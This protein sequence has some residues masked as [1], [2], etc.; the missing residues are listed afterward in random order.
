MSWKMRDP[1]FRGDSKL[2]VTPPVPST[3]LSVVA[4]ILYLG[5]HGRPT[6]YTSV[7]ELEA[8][9]E[10]FAGRAGAVWKT[11]VA[12]AKHEAAGHISRDQLER[13]LKGTGK[14]RAKWTSAWEVAQ[15]RADVIRW[16][17]HL[18]DWSGTPDEQAEAKMKATFRR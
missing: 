7:T 18:F 2:A 13:D 5:G 9:A 1:L 16:S 11:D 3:R 10:H 17:E 6:P 4:H 14:G 8:T 15:A 12:T